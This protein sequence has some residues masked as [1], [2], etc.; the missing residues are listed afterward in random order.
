MRRSS[1][2]GS[3]YDIEGFQQA[4]VSVEG[5]EF[6]YD[7]AFRAQ[8]FNRVRKRTKNKPI[9]VEQKEASSMPTILT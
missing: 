2:G 5:F 1:A 9:E 6:S 8:E 3:R 4:S 7:C